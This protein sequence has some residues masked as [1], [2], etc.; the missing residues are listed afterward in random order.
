MG[1]LSKI[2]GK[3][4]S[5]SKEPTANDRA[6]ASVSQGQINRYQGKFSPLLGRLDDMAQEDKSATQRGRSSA[7]VMQSL[8][9]TA[10]PGGTGQINPS[11]RV[12]T[13]ALGSALTSGSNNATD[14]STGLT[15]GV[16]DAATGAG[17]EAIQGLGLAA[18]LSSNEAIMKIQNDMARGKRT[19]DFLG[20]VMGGATAGAMAGGGAPAGGTDTEIG[21]FARSSYN[22]SAGKGG[23]GSGISVY[24]TPRQMNQPR[25]SFNR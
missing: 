25:I 5:S 18:K 9:S 13:R 15:K 6:L 24:Q 21:T 12:G 3:P 4:K 22:Q 2:F 17:Q 20:A 10:G 1:F 23:A 8:G 14:R 19:S 7:D 16:M 11:A